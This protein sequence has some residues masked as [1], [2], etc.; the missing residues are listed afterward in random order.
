MKL[1][2]IKEGAVQGWFVSLVFTVLTMVL[3]TLAFFIPKVTEAWVKIS[4]TYISVYQWSL[5]TWFGYKIIKHV[6]DA[7]YGDNGKPQ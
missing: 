1:E 7:K 6:A 3:L 5:T 2:I 4:T